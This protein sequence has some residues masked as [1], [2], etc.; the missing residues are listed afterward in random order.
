MLI[1]I[2]TSYGMIKEYVWN[3][4]NDFSTHEF[5]S[6]KNLNSK[7]VHYKKPHPLQHKIN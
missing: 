7:K 5:K 1:S 4:R 2:Q 3:F 6:Y